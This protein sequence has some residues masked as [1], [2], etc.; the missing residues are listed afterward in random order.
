[1]NP[2][3]DDLLELDDGEPPIDDDAQRVAAAVGGPDGF[4]RG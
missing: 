4:A 1:L 3:G 2:G